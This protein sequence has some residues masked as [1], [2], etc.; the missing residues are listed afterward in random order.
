MR[1]T[2]NELAEIQINA[3][4]LTVRN[5]TILVAKGK[6]AVRIRNATILV[7]PEENAVTMTAV[8]TRGYLPHIELPGAIYF[9]TFRLADSL[10]RHI[11]EKFAE[12][13]QVLMNLLGTK[14]RNATILVAKGKTAVTIRNATI[15]VAKEKSAVTIRNATFQVA[16][17][18]N[19]VTMT[20]VRAKLFQ[21]FAE[22]FD[23]HLDEGCG[24]S[25]LMSPVAAGI[26][27]SALKFFDGDRY[28][29]H[30]WCVMPN[31]VHILF[32]LIAGNKLSSVVS[33]WKS[34]TAN[35]INKAVGRE[36]RL[37]Q[38][39]YYDHVIRDDEEYRRIVEYIEYNPEKAGLINWRWRS[40][41]SLP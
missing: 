24:E 22:D 11:V 18:E 38:R 6:T 41:V 31:H 10:P 26:V 28:R 35:E 20:A 12:E 13:R 30:A 8:R 29:L 1:A 25:V 15:L 27:E 21:Q 7:A 4:K 9:V 14:S 40:V 39:E 17:E 33:S 5:A 37:W 36:G 19:A 2:N 23:K 16:P 32:E 34:F 3:D